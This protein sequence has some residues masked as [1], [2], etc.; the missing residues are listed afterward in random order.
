MGVPT[1]LCGGCARPADAEAGHALHPEGL[2]QGR[3]G[4][5]QHHER[6][7]MH[8]RTRRKVVHHADR[9]DVPDRAKIEGT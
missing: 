1:L 8:P 5:G 4:L 6:H 2:S 3:R 9:L 7:L